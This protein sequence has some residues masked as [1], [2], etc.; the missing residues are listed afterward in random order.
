MEPDV[1]PAARRPNPGAPRAATGGRGSRRGSGGRSIPA[2]RYS[3]KSSRPASAQWRSS[4]TRTVVP[5]SAT[6]S[7]NVRQ[8]ANASSRSPSGA[9]P[10]TD[11]R[12][13]VR[14]RS[15]AARTSSGTNSARHAAS[16]RR[17]SSGP[18]P[19]AI[20]ARRPDHLGERPEGEAL[21]VRGRSSVVPGDLL[22]DAVDVL[23]ELPGDPALA[24][25][26][27]GRRST[28]AGPSAPRGPRAGGP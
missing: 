2:T 17:A 6:R 25:A 18:S 1:V 11:Q 27:P 3:M 5:L 12:R 14:R 23:L 9:R 13:Q 28:P 7:K 24:D 16:R 26:R 4:K 21:A 8:A 10:D 20:P 22:D 15:S 19:S